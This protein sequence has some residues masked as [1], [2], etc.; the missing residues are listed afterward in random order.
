MRKTKPM[1]MPMPGVIESIELIETIEQ[2]NYRSPRCS[3]PRF[4]PV[5]ALFNST[6]T[7]VHAFF[8]SMVIQVHPFFKSTLCSSPRLFESTFVQVHACSS[9]RFV[10]VHALFKSTLHSSPRLIEVHTQEAS[11]SR[12]FT[13]KKLHAQIHFV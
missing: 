12:S 13:L 2:K 8:K 1:P 11:R 7:Q 4:F 9:P 5:H 10:Q 6:L 3:S